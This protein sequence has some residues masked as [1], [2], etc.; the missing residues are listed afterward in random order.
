MR[1][2]QAA[3]V[4]VLAMASSA[5]AQSARVQE[6]FFAMSP[7]ERKECMDAVKAT[8][9]I[10]DAAVRSGPEVVLAMQPVVCDSWRK[11]QRV[12]D[13]RVLDGMAET[14]RKL[15]CD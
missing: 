6:G 12:C 13:P 7:S 11:V 15:H 5:S 8:G 14:A 2:F 10:A 1:H 9:T 4:L 3:L